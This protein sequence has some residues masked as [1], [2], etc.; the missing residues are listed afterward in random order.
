MFKSVYFT[1]KKKKKSFKKSLN[2]SSISCQ[3]AGQEMLNGPKNFNF[4]SYSKSRAL[5]WE[6]NISGKYPNNGTDE[7][8]LFS[9]A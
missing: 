4:R 8:F 1:T 6:F 5:P 9:P 3:A 2:L 7:L